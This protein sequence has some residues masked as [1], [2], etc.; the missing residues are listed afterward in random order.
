MLVGGAL[1]F[2]APQNATREL[3]PH[4][5]NGHQ[6]VLPKLGHADNFWAYEPRASTRLIDSY[7][8]T[9]RVDTSL[10]TEN[11]LDFTPS[12]THG[13]VAE[14]VLGIFLGLAGV[15]LLSLL[16]IARRIRRGATFGWKRSVAVRSLLPLLVGFGGWFLG[17]LIALTVLPT[18]PVDDQILAI[19]SIAPPVAAVVYAAWFRRTAP[20]GIAAFA[21]L[22]TAVLGAWVADSTCRQRRRSEP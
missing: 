17:A 11:Q 20:A 15:A 9:G 7:L 22:G 5:P 19:V 4:L 13:T 12:T 16:W 8:H 6:V 14:V 1:D 18:V 21:A 3:L 10:Y 2:A